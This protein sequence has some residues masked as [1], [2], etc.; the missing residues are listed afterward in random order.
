MPLIRSLTRTRKLASLTHIRNFNSLVEEL[1]RAVTNDDEA[2]IQ[3]ID[4]AI[5]KE[6][7]AIFAADVT[8]LDERRE[9]SLFLL[10]QLVPTTQRSSLEIRIC[11]KLIKLIAD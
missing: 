3:A 4:G 8:N 1:K 5:S 7:E 10:E 9:L 11:D 6:F 2:S